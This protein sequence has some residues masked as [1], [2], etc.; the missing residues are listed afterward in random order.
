MKQIKKDIY[1][2][3]MLNPNMRVFDIIMKTEYG[4]S[5]NS[6]LIKSQKNVLIDTCHNSYT[7]QFLIKI[8]DLIDI[9][10]LNYIVVNHCEP[11]HTGS[12]IELIKLNPNIEIVCT[13]A[14][15]INLQNL[16]KGL[17]LNFKVVKYD[18]EL[19][20]GNNKVLQFKIAPFLH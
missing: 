10:N 7:K 18:D 5:Y 9:K 1:A 20:L 6:Y 4:T 17:K 2:I 13:Q 11:D 19:D 15:S 12:L 14:S 3:P 16:F 8:Q